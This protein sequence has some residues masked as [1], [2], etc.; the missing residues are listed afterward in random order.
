MDRRPLKVRSAKWA[1]SG[2]RM[3][4]NN[5]IT[6]N[7]ISILSVIFASFVLVTGM[8][9]SKYNIM[10]LVGALC[11]QLRLICNLLDGMVEDISFK[12]DSANLNYYLWFAL[13]ISGMLLV[14]KNVKN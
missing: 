10:Y 2:A 8:Y 12:K 9:S 7:M 1:S 4:A 13:A 14:I 3:L 5:G 11:I 6:P